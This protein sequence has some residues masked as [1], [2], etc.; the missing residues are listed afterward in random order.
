MLRISVSE[1]VPSCRIIKL[2]GKL[3][4]AWVDEV[5]RVCVEAEEGPLPG[6]DLSGLSFV[7]RRG[8]EMLKQLLRQGARIHACSPFVAELLHWDREIDP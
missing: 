8:A 5:R 1:R 3:L 2:E 6:L 7:D 4:E